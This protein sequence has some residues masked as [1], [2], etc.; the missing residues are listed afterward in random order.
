[1]SNSGLKGSRG[2]LGTLFLLFIVVV[3]GS[4]ILVLILYFL[5]KSSKVSNDGSD[6]YNNWGE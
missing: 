5:T 6:E 2:L 3:P 4:L 1:M